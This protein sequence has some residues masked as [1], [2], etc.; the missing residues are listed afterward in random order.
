MDKLPPFLS[1]WLKFQRLGRFG[2]RN[3]LRNPRFWLILVL[4]IGLG[5]VLVGPLRWLFDYVAL[6]ETI[7]S[8]GTEAVFLFILLFALTTSLGIPATLFPIAGGAIFGL[9][10]GSLWSLL[11][12]TLGAIV[13]FWLA[14][15]LLHDWLQRRLGHHQFMRRFNQAVVANPFIFVIAVR[16]TPFSPFSIINFLFGLTRIHSWHYSLATFIGL[17]PSIVVYTW[18]GVA[19]DQ[20]ITTGNLLPLIAASLSLLALTLL[21]LIWKRL[22]AKKVN[23]PD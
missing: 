5:L 13:A 23:D 20:L 11:G 17:V 15:Y 10:W 22:R 8:W 1:H 6:V 19:G 16:I 2:Q 4:L 3:W 9:F 18:F 14:R 21:P 7:R 12:A